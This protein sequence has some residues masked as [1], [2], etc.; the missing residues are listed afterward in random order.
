MDLHIHPP[1]RTRAV[2]VSGV[3]EALLPVA[4]VFSVFSVAGLVSEDILNTLPKPL[5][6]LMWIALWDANGRYSASL[7]ES[8][9]DR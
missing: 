1:V 6:E 8:E 2:G 7:S 9:S 4:V 3:L 5:D